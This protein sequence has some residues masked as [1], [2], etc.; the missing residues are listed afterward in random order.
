MHLLL[1][2]EAQAY[3]NLGFLKANENLNGDLVSGKQGFVVA[4][5]PNIHGLGSV[6]ST[7]KNAG[8]VRERGLLVRNTT[9]SE[10]GPKLGSCWHLCWV[11]SN[12][13]HSSFKGSDACSLT[14]MHTYLRA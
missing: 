1:S 4:H 14:S 6:L 10:R 5:L 11:A 7:I 3:Y 12:H 13:L 8:G 2:V 9:C